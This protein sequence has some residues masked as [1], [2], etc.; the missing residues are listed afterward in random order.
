VLQ[1]PL[2]TQATTENEEPTAGYM[3]REI[4]KDYLSAFTT[5][6]AARRIFKQK[7]RETFS[8]C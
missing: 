2:L 6:S 7:I 8:L 4:E 3:F 5:L 1:L